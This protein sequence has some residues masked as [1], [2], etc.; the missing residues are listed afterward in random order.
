M[1]HR[2]ERISI[3]TPRHRIVGTATLATDGYRS[4]LSDLLN[5]PEKDFISLS[6]ATVQELDGDRSLTS[7]DF[8]AVHRHHVVFAVSLGAVDEAIAVDSVI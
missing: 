1:Q 6:D 4:R 8:I 7:H 3:D 2:Y 5:A